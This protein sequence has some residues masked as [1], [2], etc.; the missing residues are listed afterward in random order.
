VRALSTRPSDSDDLEPPFTSSVASSRKPSKTDPNGCKR[1]H[2]QRVPDVPSRHAVVSKPC[3]N[4]PG[5]NP[6]ALGTPQRKTQP[7]GWVESGGAGNRTHWDAVAQPADGA[8]LSSPK[9]C[10][11]AVSSS[12]RSPRESAR[13]DAHRPRAWRHFGDGNEARR[14]PSLR[15]F[16]LRFP[17]TRRC[18]ALRQRRRRSL[19]G[20]ERQKAAPTLTIHIKRANRA[21]QNL[22]QR[23]VPLLVS[24]MHLGQRGGRSLGRRSGSH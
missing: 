3:M 7:R 23:Q 4:A 6:G 11:S 19:P 17:G 5:Q 1:P 24:G 18:T 8:R 20:W 9:P 16:R 15:L 21:E 22:E 2:R 13:V 10:G 12:R 14:A